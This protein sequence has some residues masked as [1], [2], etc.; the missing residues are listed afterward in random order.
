VTV[1]DPQLPGLDEVI[2]SRA[3]DVL[4]ALENTVSLI[5]PDPGRQTGPSLPAPHSDTSL[6]PPEEISAAVRKIL[7]PTTSSA[8]ERELSP[9]IDS[10]ELEALVTAVVTALREA[11][12]GPIRETVRAVTSDPA[13][14]KTLRRI[15]DDPGLSPETISNVTRNIRLSGGAAS[16]ADGKLIIAALVLLLAAGIAVPLLAK[17]AAETILTNEVAISALAVSIAALRKG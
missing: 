4:A 11:G 12:S 1:G 9:S 7:E 8:H 5:E 2:Q 6:T 17:A 13:I 14:F 15:A 16:T 10:A 3:G